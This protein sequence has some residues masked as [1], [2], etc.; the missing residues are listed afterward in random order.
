MV[1]IVSLTYDVIII[2]CSA[3][4]IKMDMDSLKE[5]KAFIVLLW[6]LLAFIQMSMSMETVRV[7]HWRVRLSRLRFFDN[8]PCRNKIIKRFLGHIS[9]DVS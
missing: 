2:S 7:V 3:L 9:G 4:Y 6:G 1:I 5:R 8:L